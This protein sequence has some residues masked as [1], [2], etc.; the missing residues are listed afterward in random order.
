MTR[1]FNE[2]GVKK[3]FNKGGGK[4]VEAGPWG[5]IRSSGEKN[6]LRKLAKALLYDIS[7]YLI[8]KKRRAW[9][10]DRQG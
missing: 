5:V 8:F 3:R 2:V 7:F 10:G 1:A 9:G 6:L 4:G